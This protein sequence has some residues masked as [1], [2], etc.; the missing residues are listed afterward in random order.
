MRSS[1]SSRRRRG[2]L[3]LVPVL[4]ASVAAT[5]PGV[6]TAHEFDH[7]PP[8]IGNPSAPD[9]STRTVARDGGRFQ[10]LTS[11]P[12]GN[13][14]SDLDFFSK[15]GETYAAVGT[16]AIGGNQGGQSIVKL[17]EGGQVEPNGRPAA[18]FVTGHPS[19]ACREPGE[20]RAGPAARRGGHPE[21]GHR[22]QQRLLPAGRPVQDR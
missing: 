9:P 7:A 13:P 10:L 20:P 14:H 22:H 5:L 17:T 21:V 6:A 8:A 1:P 18:R 2:A 3:A 15:G 19:A 16:L 11:I 4:A 12:T